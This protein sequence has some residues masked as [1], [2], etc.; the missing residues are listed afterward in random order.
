MRL[1]SPECCLVHLPALQLAVSMLHRDRLSIHFRRHDIVRVNGTDLRIIPEHLGHPD[2]ASSVIPQSRLP[3]I[4][5]GDVGSL[6]EL[7]GSHSIHRSPAV[8]DDLIY[9]ISL[10]SQLSNY[11]TPDVSK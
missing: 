1:I 3:S 9:T 10:R 4:A 11:Y 6:F 7:V 5:K 2:I 8:E